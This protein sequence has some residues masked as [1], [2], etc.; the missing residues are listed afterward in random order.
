MIR[1]AVQPHDFD[2]GE[3]YQQLVTD[4]P[5]D[6]AVVTFVGRV[7]D[8]NQQT[9]ITALE[10]EHYPGMTETC[11]QRIAEQAFQRWPLGK[12]RVIHRYGKLA[13][14][15][16]IVLVAT[17][18]PHRQAAFESAAFIMDYLKTQAPF[19]KKET[20]SQGDTHWVAANPND[21]HAATQWDTTQPNAPKRS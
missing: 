3:E 8:L 10:L 1:V 4:A 9:T 17:T 20:T 7:R 12:V 2:V 19:W 13:P 14:Q 6:G 5:S 21:Q 11:L 18:S 16:Q 15:D